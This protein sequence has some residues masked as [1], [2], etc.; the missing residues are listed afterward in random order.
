MKPSILVISGPTATG[1]TDLFLRLV[2]QGYAF[3]ALVAD[4]RQ[5]YR[6]MDIGTGKDLPSDP[7][8]RQRFWLVDIIDP[9]EA[10]SS[11][12]FCRLAD[13]AIGHI[14]ASGR[15]PVLVG[16]TGRYIKDMETQP[17]TLKVPPNPELRRQLS[18]LSVSELQHRLKQ[19]NPAK[20]ANMNNSDRNNPR[21]LI[22]AIEVGRNNSESPTS[23]YVINTI[24][25]TA[26]L[27]L[28]EARIKQRV[29]IRMEQGMIA[30]VTN[31]LKKYPDFHTYQASAT[32]GYT[33]II[34]FLDHQLSL[35]EAID[36]WTRREIAYAKRQLTWL[37]H[38]TQAVWFDISQANWYAEVVKQLE[39]WD[40]GRSHS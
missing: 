8:L 27:Q 9:N 40:Y 31:L 37:E 35:T 39:K 22:R 26:P 7:K 33:E 34:Q 10:F 12:L 16:G 24:C 3:D 5:V 19:R 17:S 23:P 28:I 21:R 13:Q 20:L 11:A 4:S 38:Q 36:K 6:Y 32:P 18:L 30:E 25:L 15:Q 2:R 1:K 29:N 14:I